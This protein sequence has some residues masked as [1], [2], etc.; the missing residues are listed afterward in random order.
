V[1]IDN[2][3]CYWNWVDFTFRTIPVLFWMCGFF[4]AIF[5]LFISFCFGIKSGFYK[6]RIEWFDNLRVIYVL[7]LAFLMVFVT[8]MKFT[9]NNYLNNY[10][11]C[12]IDFW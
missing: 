3:V 9:G 8:F 4:A 6:T 12:L 10:L 5:L 1:S 2:Y 11:K 7:V